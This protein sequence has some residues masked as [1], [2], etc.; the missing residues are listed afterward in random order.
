M[1]RQ[2][3]QHVGASTPDCDGLNSLPDVFRAA[4]P[5]SKGDDVSERHWPEAGAY[6]PEIGL[7]S[8]PQFRAVTETG[9]GH[10]GDSGAGEALDADCEG[11]PR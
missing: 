7:G 2:I 4:A 9:T 1:T 5:A 10:L 11:G 3:R 6:T 8:L